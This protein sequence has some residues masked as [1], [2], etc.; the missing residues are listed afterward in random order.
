MLQS[1]PDGWVPASLAQQ[2]IWLNEQHRDVGSVYHL[3]FT[4]TFDGSLEKPALLA[5]AAAVVRRHP[6]LASTFT[7]RDGQL[8]VGPV[9]TPPRVAVM[10]AP[11]PAPGGPDRWLEQ[12]ICYAIR[13]PFDLRG[14][15]LLR[16]QLFALGTDH[17][18]LLVVPHHL[19]FDGTSMELYKEDLARCYAATLDDRPPPPADV[20]SPAR[21]AED[22]QR[23][24]T[25]LLPAAR[26]FWRSRWRDP[27]EMC[28]PGVVNPVG[29]I[30][31]DGDCVEVF[32]EQQW[33]SRLTAAAET[34]GVTRLESLLASLAALLYRY[35]N[36]EP[37]VTLAIGTSIEERGDSIGCFGGELPVAM[38][39]PPG[40]TFGD[41]AAAV[42]ADL[43]ELYRFRDI[44]LNRAVTGVRRSAMHTAVSL[45]Y[46]RH[47][48][49]VTFPG[50]RVMARWRFSLAARGA[51]WIQGLHEEG[52]LRLFFRYSPRVVDRDSVVRIATHWRVLVEGATADP[53]ALVEELPVLDPGERTALLAGGRGG[54]GSG[55]AAGH[56][57]AADP[58]PAS[59][60]ALL[61]VQFTE[62]PEKV[63]AVCGTRRVTYASLAAEAG[64]LA[65]RLV[66][67]GVRPG[68]SVA[69]CAA[70]SIDALVG[71]LAALRTGG[72]CIPLGPAPDAATLAARLGAG[73]AV[74]LGDPAVVPAG[75]SV[76]AGLKVIRLDERGC[77]CGRCPAAGPA[78]PVTTVGGYAFG[79]TAV[80]IGYDAIAERLAAVR[81]L[82]GA[83]ATDIWLT[84]AP[85]AAARAVFEQL[86]PLALGARLVIA[87]PSD[88]ADATRLSR[89]V[90]RHRVTHLPA[91]PAGWERLLDAGFPGGGVVALACGGGSL[92]EPLARRLRSRVRRLWYLHGWPET[93]VWT[94]G[95]EI[96]PEPGTPTIGRPIAGA[97]VRL[98]TR[99]GELAPLGLAGNV[100][101]GGPGLADGYLGNPGRTA[102]RFVPDQFGPPG[103]RLYRT[104]HRARYRGDGQLVPV[105]PPGDRP[106]PDGLGTRATAA[107]GG[108]G[109]PDPDPA[110]PPAAEADLQVIAQICAEVLRIGS[111][112]PQ[113][114]L[115]D[116][117][118]SSLV[119]AR[120]AA[121]I[122]Q[123]LK[124][125]IPM[126]LLYDMPTV[127]GI[128]A[129]VGRQRIGS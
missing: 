97:R 109:P 94:I 118:V 47:R 52:G 82:T 104:G 45:T 107:S 62:R 85:A 9:A 102:A 32:L 46:R 53:T 92:P 111:V 49:G 40:A 11:E 84:H 48:T 10:D 33:L 117:G 19:V 122:Q 61:A 80:T 22:Q 100:Y 74:L 119:L 73:A 26:R 81:D 77:A 43:R 108:E 120:I 21:H 42:R 28:L 38:P 90:E 36:D 12:A 103:A 29:D 5:A 51:L 124:V 114:N 86:L 115:F 24:L 56:G 78:A 129:L 113:Q 39:V 30:D 99:R 6:I 4:L 3:P 55:R 59:L 34:L 35:G 64:Q 105:H 98:V 88:A 58:A 44:P 128:A 123:L 2:G 66:C 60:P 31:P 75:P 121:R 127:A 71:Q 23:M 116:S 65:R 83:G 54:A 70:P 95:T 89:L 110:Q 87:E 76:P 96:P 101:V 7:E 27:A 106:G 72:V 17:H 16:M 112:G 57:A 1:P 79:D 125:D 25:E 41:F 15:P 67:A 91:T 63:A 68:T 18:V 37:V 20:Y 14:G 13:Q 50:V 69:V 126:D 93:G 8:Y